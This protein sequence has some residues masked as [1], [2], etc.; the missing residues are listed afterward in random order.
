MRRI[1]PASRTDVELCLE[2]GAGY[3]PERVVLRLRSLDRAG[4]EHSLETLLT[5]IEARRFG[6]AVLDAISKSDRTWPVSI[7]PTHEHERQQYFEVETSEVESAPVLVTL[8]L[9]GANDGADSFRIPLAANEA[10][11][12]GHLFLSAANPSHLASNDD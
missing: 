3:V 6:H 5:S 1:C 11:R 4:S 2:V 9:R 10:H 12:L 7:R 8:R